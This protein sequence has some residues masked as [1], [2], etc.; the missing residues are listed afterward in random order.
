MSVGSFGAI[1]EVPGIHLRLSARVGESF[2]ISFTP[3]TPGK[4]LFVCPIPGHASAGMVTTVMV[5]PRANALTTYFDHTVCTHLDS[6]CMGARVPEP[7]LAQY[8]RHT[9]V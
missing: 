9:E 3:S 2:S 7:F 6:W 1:Y 4:Y 5:S 8:T